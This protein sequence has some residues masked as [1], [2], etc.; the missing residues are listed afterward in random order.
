[1]IGFHLLTLSQDARGQWQNLTL[2]LASM[3][4]VCLRDMRNMTPLVEVIPAKYIPD[5][6]RVR[7]SPLPLVQT[8]VR[9]LTRHL[10]HDDLQIRETARDALGSELDPKLYG[11]LIKHLEE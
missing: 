10:I 6:I 11:R 5:Q 4:G 9:D 1:M 3:G 7:S 2:F 8:F